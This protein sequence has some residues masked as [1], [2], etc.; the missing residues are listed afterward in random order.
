MAGWRSK[1]KDQDQLAQE[2]QAVAKKLIAAIRELD[3]SEAGKLAAELVE[4]IASATP[5]EAK[6]AE[7]SVLYT[8]V[9]RLRDQ[10]RKFKERDRILEKDRHHADS[11]V[12]TNVPS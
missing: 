7:R 3:D 9:S 1:F 11:P 10:D 8:Y 5:G 12:D 2:F 4:E 6:T